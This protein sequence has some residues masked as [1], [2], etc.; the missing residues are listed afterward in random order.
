[1]LKIH[2]FMYACI[3]ARGAASGKEALRGPERAQ[4]VDKV[5]S[6]MLPMPLEHAQHL[7]PLGPHSLFLSAQR[8]M[9]CM[10]LTKP[11]TQ[12]S[13]GE[14]G[15]PW[16]GQACSLLARELAWVLGPESGGEWSWIRLVTSHEWCSPRGWYWDLSCSVSLFITWTRG[17]SK[18]SVSLQITS[19]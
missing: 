7:Q 6:L 12:Y 13:P 3:W 11:L 17:L 19:S 1:M 8:T 14:A 10:P 5:R 15:S 9:G 2:S 4:S 18:P 16:L